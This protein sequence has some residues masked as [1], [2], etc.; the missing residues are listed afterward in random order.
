ML[1]TAQINNT[2]S[3]YNY[4][5]NIYISSVNRS[6]LNYLNG[7]H[8]AINN[9]RNGL[10]NIRECTLYTA[11]YGGMHYYKLMDA[12]EN[13]QIMTNNLKSVE[14]IDYGCGQAFAT[15]LLLEYLL[16]EGYALNNIKIR[17][18]D[19]SSVAIANGDLYINKL[20]SSYNKA[21]KYSITKDVIDIKGLNTIKVCDTKSDTL[22]I[23]LFSNI[24]DIYYVSAKPIVEYIVNN[25][26]GKNYFICTS[27]SY[28]KTDEKF[29]IFKNMIKEKSTSLTDVRKSHYDLYGQYYKFSGGKEFINGRITRVEQQF[30]AQL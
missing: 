8:N 18:N 14:I 5:K 22:K 11:L 15:I 19:I 6:G 21:D 23:H 2:D 28:Y 7:E 9:G 25:Y 27:P 3:K 1:K 30:I 10:E 13:S 29:T 24:L 20:L 17:L 12:Y 26:K 16:S 4:Y